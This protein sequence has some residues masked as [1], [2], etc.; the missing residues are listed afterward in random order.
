MG[1]VKLAFDMCAKRLFRSIR[2]VD[3]DTVQSLLGR[4]MWKSIAIFYNNLS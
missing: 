2:R 4:I 3:T 1:R